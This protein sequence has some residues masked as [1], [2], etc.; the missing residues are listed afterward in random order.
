MMY[1]LLIPITCFIALTAGAD[2][3][4]TDKIESEGTLISDQKVKFEE[5]DIITVLVQE[6]VT[7][8]TRSET[9]TEK[10]SDIRASAPIVSNP[11][12]VANPPTGNG[13]FNPSELPNWNIGIDNEHE[14]E[15]TTR[16]RNEFT[17]TI[18]CVVTKVF[19]NGNIEIEG[20]KSVQV[21]REETQVAVKGIVRGRDVTAGNTIL[22]TQIA[23]ADVKL[24]GSGP[25]WNNQRRGILT[26]ILDW[27]SPF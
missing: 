25:L 22:S 9:S 3:L 23:N 2:S 19:E 15:G 1:R 26:K 10:Q 7:A 18:S 14:S 17:T 5:G 11:F 20:E 24:K 21:N 6:S 4:F 8:R 27:F 13:I 12:L 16:R